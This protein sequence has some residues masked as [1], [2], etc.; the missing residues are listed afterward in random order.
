MNTAARTTRGNSISED[1][2]SKLF[3]KIDNL[4]T[5]LK[6]EFTTG[7]NNAVT[8]LEQS[9]AEGQRHTNARVHVLELHREELER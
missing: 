9:I 6:A 7:I 8:K 1:N 2:F 5:E 4:S 3:E